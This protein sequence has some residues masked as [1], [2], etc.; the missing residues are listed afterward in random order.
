MNLPQLIGIAVAVGSALV[1][2]HL[3]GE[4]LA[5]ANAAPLAGGSR[6]LPQGQREP[7]CVV[8]P[9][10]CAGESGRAELSG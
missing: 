10:A 3:G 1:G 6:G 7:A 9:P 5:C 2:G 4:A 8:G